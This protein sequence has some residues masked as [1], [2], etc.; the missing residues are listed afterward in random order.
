MLV[1]H[2]LKSNPLIVGLDVDSL[3]RAR[4]LVSDLSDLVGAFKLGPRL[5]HRYGESLIQEMAAQ[6]PVFVDCKFFDIPSTMLASV[7]ASFEAG[8]SLVTVHAMAG[9][10]ALK[11]LAELEAEL[12]KERPFLILAVTMLT[13]FSDETLPP[14]LKPQPISGH[15]RELA[16]MAKTCGIR[17]LVCSGEELSVLEDLEMYL[18]TPGIRFTKETGQDQKRVVGPAEAFSH[19]AS[20]IVV[21]RPIIEAAKPREVAIN[22]SI[23]MLKRQQG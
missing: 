5:I 16:E 11:Q 9:P 13:S 14:N 8:A 12:C 10:E 17:G 2:Q 18:V 20:A 21:A 4:E 6:A 1:P 23:S 7:R 3:V 15:V 19:G 22:Y